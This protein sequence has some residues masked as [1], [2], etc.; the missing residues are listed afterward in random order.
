MSDKQVYS[1]FH[2]YGQRERLIELILA[3]TESLRL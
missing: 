3:H 2:N 1:F